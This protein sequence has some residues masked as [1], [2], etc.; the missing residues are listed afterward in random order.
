MNDVTRILSAI[1]QGDPSAAGELLPLV[2]EELRKLAAQRLSQERPGQTLQATALVHEAYLRLIGTDVGQVQH[3]NSRGHFF[4]AAAEAMRRILVDR[5]R[6]RKRLKRNGDRR[7]IDLDQIEMALDTPSEEL[8]A[9]DESL[10]KLVSE[11]P[12]CA[13]LVKLRF[14]AGMSLKDAAVALGVPRRT[15]DRHWAFARAWLH[16]QLHRDPPP[17]AL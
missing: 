10:E 11:Y 6:N 8:L 17:D 2:Y 9:L 16:R 14:F 7:W 4:G 3:W 15:A 1:E 5:A 12:E 13:Q